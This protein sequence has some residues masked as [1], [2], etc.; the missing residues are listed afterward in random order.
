M[1]IFLYFPELYNL[2]SIA[3]LSYHSVPTASHPLQPV[4]LFGSLWSQ[5]TR[6]AGVRFRTRGDHVLPDDRSRAY[7]PSPHLYFSVVA[8]QCR[9]EAGLLPH[10][11]SRSCSPPP[12]RFRMATDAPESGFTTGSCRRQRTLTYA[13]RRSLQTD[14]PCNCHSPLC[15][16]RRPGSCANGG[17]PACRTVR[18]LRRG[19]QAWAAAATTTTTLAVTSAGGPGD[20]VASKTVVALTA[21]VTAGST[22]VNRGR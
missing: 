2:V 4:R 13:D 22:A 16:A 6:T 9:R 5:Q 10:Y 11:V 15:A 12:Y 20:D 21:T 3:T 19:A 1:E 18:P 14:S 17:F 8:F 7:F